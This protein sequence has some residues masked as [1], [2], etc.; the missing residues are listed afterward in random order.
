MYR[1][2]R[3]IDKIFRILILTLPGV[4]PKPGI[5]TIEEF[6]KRKFNWIPENFKNEIGHFNVFRLEPFA[7]DKVQPAPYKRRDYYKIMLVIGSSKGHYADR[8]VEVKKQ[9]LSFSNPQIPYKWEHLDNI[10][11]GSFCIFNEHFFH[12][13]GNLHQ[14]AVFQP[15]GTHI[16]EL[17]DNQVEKISVIYDQMFE[18]IDSDYKHKAE[19]KNL[20]PARIAIAWLL[21]QKPWIVPIPG[22]TKSARLEENVGAVEVEL[23]SDY[24]HEIDEAAAKIKIEGARYPDSANRLVGR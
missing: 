21:S 24:L 10:R 18:E 11:K 15:N 12:K 7:G 6:Y 4:R 13:Y 23:T 1:E 2:F 20:T 16:L 22:T 9:A 14:Y 3:N 5:D 8:I 19:Q 17:S